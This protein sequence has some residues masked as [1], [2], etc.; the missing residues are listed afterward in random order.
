MKDLSELEIF[1]GETP[2][3]Q[4]YAWDFSDIYSRFQRLIH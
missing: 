1:E 3:F 2:L 4:C